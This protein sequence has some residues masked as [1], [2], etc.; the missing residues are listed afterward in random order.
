VTPA[1]LMAHGIGP[2]PELGRLL[3]RCREIEDET[4][5]SDPERILARCLARR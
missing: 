4:G 1:A 3:R 2:G 5:W